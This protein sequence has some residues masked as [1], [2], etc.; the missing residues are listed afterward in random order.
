MS[1]ASGPGSPGSGTSDPLAGID[2]AAGLT[3]VAGGDPETITLM[4]L[5]MRMFTRQAGVSPRLRRL[6]EDMLEGRSTIDVIMRDPEFDSIVAGRLD[7]VTTAIERLPEDER[8]GPDWFA[9]RMADGVEPTTDSQLSALMRR[10]DPTAARLAD[11]DEAELRGD[12]DMSGWLR[13]RH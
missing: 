8:P 13:A 4:R 2:D 12:D 6:V 10:A 5:S 7:N 9:A 3:R 11:R 1:T